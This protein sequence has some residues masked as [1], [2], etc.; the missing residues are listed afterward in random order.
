MTGLPTG[1]VTFLMTDVEGSTVLWEESPEAMRQAM[2]RHHEILHRAIE[3]H[4]GGRR[5]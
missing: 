4:S 2:A 3:Q 1:T 5:L